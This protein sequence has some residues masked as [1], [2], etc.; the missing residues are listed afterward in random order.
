MPLAWTKAGIESLLCLVC[1]VAIPFACILFLFSCLLLLRDHAVVSTPL[2]LTSILVKF[3]SRA[4]PS[5]FIHSLFGPYSGRIPASLP[6]R[7]DRR[8]NTHTTSVRRKAFRRWNHDTTAYLR[9]TALHSR[10]N[11]ILYP[12]KHH[13]YSE[14]SVR[15][16][17]YI[18]NE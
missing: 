15:R 5:S 10:H 11:S 1:L 4:G 3:A 7:L 12:S 18:N 8:L 2:S 13:R 6:Q 9:S 17:K 16:I 14:S